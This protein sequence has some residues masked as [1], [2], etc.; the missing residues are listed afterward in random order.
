MGSSDILSLAV[1]AGVLVLVTGI[2]ICISMRVRRG[3]GS[4]TTAI[5]GATDGFLTREKSKAAETIVND[6]AGKTFQDPRVK[7]AE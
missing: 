7:S 1:V 2:F 4:L 5:L 6:N 3:G